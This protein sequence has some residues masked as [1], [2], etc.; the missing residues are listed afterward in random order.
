VAQGKIIQAKKE[1]KTIPKGW[2]VDPDGKDT[3][4]TEK[5]LAGAMLPFGG[6]KGY[7][8][9]L[10]IQILCSVLSGANTDRNIPSFWNNFE[11][12][13]NLGNFFGVLKIDA[14]QIPDQFY[15]Q[16]KIRVDSIKNTKPSPGVESVMLPGEIE[17]NAQHRAEREGIELTEAISQDILS[18]AD[19]YQVDAHVLLH[20]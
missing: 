16:M 8:I 10:L 9:G 17:F 1:G 19:E 5:A 13:Q 12:P 20:K 18:L 11:D 4:D 6:P 3:T 7:A 2:A 14:F 15:S